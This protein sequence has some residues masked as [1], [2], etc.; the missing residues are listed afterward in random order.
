MGSSLEAEKDIAVLH[1]SAVPGDDRSDDAG[2]FGFDFIH[3]LHG[4]DDTDRLADGNGG[5]DFNEIGSIRRGF[6][7]ERANHRRGDF[8]ACRGRDGNGRSGGGRSGGGGRWQAGEKTAEL[9]HV[10]TFFQLEVKILLGEIEERESV[11]IHEFYDATDFLEVHGA[12]KGWMLVEGK[13]QTG[14]AA[15]ARSA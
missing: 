13:R 14:H 8:T 5:T 10:S 9:I 15:R 4:L 12:R 7:I 2:L 11:L 3:D 1:G 6:Q